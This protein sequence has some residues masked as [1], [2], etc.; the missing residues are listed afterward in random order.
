MARTVTVEKRKRGFAGWLARILFWGWTL[1]MGAMFVIAFMAGGRTPA[2]TEAEKVGSG[3]GILLASSVVFWIWALG[4]L[5]LGIF[6][7]ATRGRKITVTE[8][9]E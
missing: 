8:T 5:V 3:L 4:A 1:V 6:V 9:V 7:L 2:E